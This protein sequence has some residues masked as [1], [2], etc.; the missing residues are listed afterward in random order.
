MQY[1][2]VFPERWFSVIHSNRESFN[3]HFWVVILI[4]FGL[5]THHHTMKP[6]FRRVTGYLGQEGPVTAESCKRSLSGAGAWTGQE[7]LAEDDAEMWSLLQQEK[8]RQCRGLEL[9]ASEVRFTWRVRSRCRSE[10]MNW[11]TSLISVPLYFLIR[12]HAEKN[13]SMFSLD[14]L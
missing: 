3:Y 11:C 14:S 8:D 7:S 9:I 13:T 6:L 1:C 12:D 5:L 10:K 2:L 4:V